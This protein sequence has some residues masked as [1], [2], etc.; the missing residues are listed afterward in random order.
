MPFFVHRPASVNR[1][2]TSPPPRPCASVL[3]NDVVD[4]L[5]QLDG[6]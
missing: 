4:L 2:G 3:Q 5:V 1:F 6:L